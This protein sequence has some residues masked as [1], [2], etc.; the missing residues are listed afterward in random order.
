MNYISRQ[1]LPGQKLT[2][3]NYLQCNRRIKPDRKP[4]PIPTQSNYPQG[5]LGQKASVTATIDKRSYADVVSGNGKFIFAVSVLFG[6]CRSFLRYS[7]NHVQSYISFRLIGL[8]V[9]VVVKVSNLLTLFSFCD[10]MF[11]DHK[12][13]SLSACR[14]MFTVRWI[15]QI[16]FSRISGSSEIL[17]FFLSYNFSE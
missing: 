2:S 4:K 14:N 5:Y 9:R 16:I 8:R 1:T 10:V 3:G 13:K 7:P 12:N 15:L 11:L 17:R 6:V